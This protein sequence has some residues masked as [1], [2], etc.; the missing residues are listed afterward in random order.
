LNELARRSRTIP[1]VALFSGYQRAW[2]RADLT[3]GLVL[4]AM[5]VPQGMAY[6][7]LTGL[8]AYTGIYTTIAALLAYSIFGPNRR[9]VL[10]PD[11][12]L[13]PVIAAVVLPLAAGDPASA[14]VLA[15]AMSII[16]GVVCV[17]AGYLSLGVVTEF[18]S[19]PLRIGY[20]NGIAVVIFISQVPKA[21]GFSIA[22]ESTLS[23]LADTTSAVL[24]HEI[25]PAALGLSLA[26]VLVIVVLQRV[27]RAIPGVI[28]AAVGSIAA[29]S[30]FDLTGVSTVG[31]IPSGLPGLVIPSV[32]LSLVPTLLGGAVAVALVSFADTGALSTATALKSGEHVDPNSEIKALGAA[33]ILSG[34]FQGF[35]T[36]ASSSRTAVAMAVGARSQMA[37]L[38]AALGV[39]VIIVFAPGL[40]SDIP[41]PTLAAIVITA[42]FTLFDW[43][44]VIWLWQVRRSEFILMLAAFLGVL[45]LGVLEGIGVAIVLSLGNLVRKVWRPHSTE[46]GRVAG[47]P[48]FHDRER[49]PEAEV[50]P[51]L[52]IARYDAPIFFANASD[53][54]RRLQQLMRTAGRPIERVILVGNAITDIDTTGAEI[55]D[56]LLDDL[57]SRDMGFAFAGLKGPVKDRLRRYG[58]YDR[59]GD[60]NFFPNTL[61]AVAFHEREHGQGA[62]D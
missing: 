14:V 31:A 53:F 1:L 15:S 20:L 33:N 38:V 24:G 26:S 5:L 16:A 52:L 10:G 47:M 54:G 25:V 13:A 32:D 40:V 48:G 2:A 61:S 18:L 12:S 8:P 35:A 56:H 17:A 41:A 28:V 45:V 27:T 21:L 6:A 59:V 60:E 51:G 49:H 43:K 34:L 50:V 62:T 39:V 46:L 30:L 11:S 3:A 58:L 22:A 37:G 9:L 44:G 42:S 36:S 57:E 7:Q 23:T 29:V 55:L 4:A 19:K